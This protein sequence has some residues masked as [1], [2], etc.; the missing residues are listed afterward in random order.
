MAKTLSFPTL[1]LA[2]MV[3]AGNAAAGER[4]A[5]IAIPAGTTVSLI[6]GEATILCPEDASA[7]ALSKGDPV[8]TACEIATG[9]SS[10]LELVLP[11]R[12]VIRFAEKTTFV[13]ISAEGSASGP[14]DV[15]L[16][17][18]T[19]KI[20]SFVRRAIGKPDRFDVSCQNAVAG[21]RGT[22]YQVAVFQDQSAV[23]KVFEGA[24]WVSSPLKVQPPA[25][26]QAQPAPIEGPRAV[27]GPEPV[28]LEKWSFIVAAKQQIAISADGRA[29]LP[30]TFADAPDA[31]DWLDWNRHRDR[32]L[33]SSQGVVSP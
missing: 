18:Q 21:V 23:V 25:A 32:T 13:L 9:P 4:I 14:R 15:R 10:R 20:W 24:V 12:S 16:R 7:V 3:L 29:G 30:E 1:L 33:R 31:D 2:F 22:V 6:S 28:S 5:S 26:S 27:P 8:K 11:D 17:L 19:G